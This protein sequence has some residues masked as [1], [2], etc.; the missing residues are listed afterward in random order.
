MFKTVIYKL[1]N[2]VLKYQKYLK[3]RILFLRDT[4]LKNMNYLCKRYILSK[5]QVFNTSGLGFTLILCQ[6][7]DSKVKMISK[8]FIT[9]LLSNNVANAF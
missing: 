1:T 4:I 7:E 9:Q 8:K 5:F 6:L 3:Y 2:L